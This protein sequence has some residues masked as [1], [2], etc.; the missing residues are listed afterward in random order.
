MRLIHLLL[1]FSFVFTSSLSSAQNNTDEEYVVVKKKKLNQRRKNKRAMTKAIVEL[2]TNGALL[3]MIRDK[4]INSAM[5]TEKGMENK[6]KEIEERQRTRNSIIVKGLAK[7][8]KFC[9]IYFFYQS[10]LEKIQQGDIQANLVDTNLVKGGVQFN[11]KYFLILDYGDLYAEPGKTYSDTSA[12]D[13]T[14][15][16]VMKNNTFV[17]K[18]KYLSQLVDP[19]PYYITCHYPAKDI[20]YRANKLSI[21]LTKFYR[22]QAE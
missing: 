3:Y 19:F 8:F 16:T 5:L 21:K 9:P 2:K 22:K 15:R 13:Q 7:G 6:A 11:H 12:Y 10:D 17:I 18:N 4:K 1:L 20:L 14:G